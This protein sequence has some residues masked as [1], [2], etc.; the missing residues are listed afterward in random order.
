MIP[1]RPADHVWQ[2]IV[3]PLAGNGLSEQRWKRLLSR[4]AP[5]IPN[6]RVAFSHQPGEGATIARQALTDG[7][8]HILTVGG[9]GTHHDVVNGIR[10]TMGDQSAEVIYALLPIGTGND[11]IKTHGIPRRFDRWLEVFQAGQLHRQNIG[12]LQFQGKTGLVQHYFANVAGLAYDGFV[13]KM[14]TDTSRRSGGKWFYLMLTLRCL[15]Q[16]TP[17]WAT[18]TYDDTTVS[19]YFYTINVG[20]CRFSGGGMQLTPHA[21]PTGDR[22]ALTYARSVSRLQVILNTYRFYNGTLGKHPRIHTTFAH[23]IHIDSPADQPIYLEADG[24]L[25]GTTPVTIQLLRN[26]LTFIGPSPKK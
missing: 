7:L 5:L 24:E 17:E 11:W 6:H 18:I 9:D 8:R 1:I 22:L 25:L 19:D 12:Q 2:V 26:A 15:F 13:V 16:Y 3:N 23:H 20:V 4:L 21:Q 10:N 14:G